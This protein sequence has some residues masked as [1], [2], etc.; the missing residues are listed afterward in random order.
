MSIGPNDRTFILCK[1]N[2]VKEN[3]ATGAKKL[4]NAI[5]TPKKMTKPYNMDTKKSF[6]FDGND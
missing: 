4:F 2:M 3:N 5:L 6:A 1:T